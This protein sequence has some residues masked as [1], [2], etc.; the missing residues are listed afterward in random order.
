[1]ENSENIQNDQKPHQ[2]NPSLSDDSATYDRSQPVEVENEGERPKKEPL[3][4]LEVI[5]HDPNVSYTSSDEE[6]DII[7]EEKAKNHQ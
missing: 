7:R 4:G 6:A 2:Q 5:P 1:M 3:G